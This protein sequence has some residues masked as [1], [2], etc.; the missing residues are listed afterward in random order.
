VPERMCIGCREREAK[1]AL[2]RLVVSGERLVIDGGGSMP[3]RAG[4]LHPGDEC[5]RQFSRRGGFIRSLRRVVAKEERLRV[6][7]QIRQCMTGGQVRD[8]EE[9]SW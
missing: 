8:G 7:H 6:V 3:G 2:V 9:K 1:S 4:Y 5:A